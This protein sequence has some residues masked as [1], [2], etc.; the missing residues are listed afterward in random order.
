M[1]SS[2]T[3]VLDREGLIR[4]FRRVSGRRLVGVVD[5][6]DCVELVFEDPDGIG[7]NLVSVFTDG[8]RL[9]NVCLGFVARDPIEAGYGAAEAQ[10]S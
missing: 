7:E 1:T 9:G 10:G 2:H 5:G 4:L 6:F 3:T 8:R